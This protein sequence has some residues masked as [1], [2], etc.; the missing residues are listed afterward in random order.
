VNK[1]SFLLAS[2]VLATPACSVTAD[3]V[4]DTKAEAP[5]K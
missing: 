3:R 5:A 2:L 4:D 1:K